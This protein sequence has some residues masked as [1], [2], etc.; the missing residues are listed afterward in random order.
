MMTGIRGETIMEAMNGIMPMT[1]IMNGEKPR[2]SIFK[3]I[4][5]YM[6]PM[7]SP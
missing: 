5:G 6:N 7:L 1:P 4:N 3:L 2:D